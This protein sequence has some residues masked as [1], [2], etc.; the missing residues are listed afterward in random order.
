MKRKALSWLLALCL[1][2]GLLPTAAL[3]AEDDVGDDTPVVSAEPEGDSNSF[4]GIGDDTVEK[5]LAALNPA[6]TLNETADTGTSGGIVWSYEDGVLT[7][8]AAE[9]PESGYD[10]GQMKDYTDQSKKTV[11]IPT[12]WYSVKDEITKVVI[13]NDVTY[14]G[15]WAFSYLINAKEANIPS[16]IKGLGGYLFRGD[17]ELTNV[18]W[19]KNFVAPT[20]TDTDNPVDTYT[21]QY[22]PVSMFDFCYKLGDGIELTDWLPDSF[23]GVCCASLRGTQFTVNFD[24]WENLKYIG[25]YSFSQMPNLN[26]FTMKTDITYGLRNH[27]TTADP[28]NNSNAFNGSGLKSLE[29]PEG[30]TEIFGCMYINCKNLRSISLPSTLK[31]IGQQAFSDCE[32]LDELVINTTS[33]EMGWGV[34]YNCTNLK[35][36]VLK[37]NIT[38]NGTFDSLESVEIYGAVTGSITLSAAKDIVIAGASASMISASKMKTVENLTILGGAELAQYAFLRNTTL[39]NLTFSN[40]LGTNTGLFR[41]SS[42]ETVKY[43]GT[44]T[45]ALAD[46]MFMGCTNLKW[47]D[48]SSA[49]SVTV[50]GG[51]FADDLANNFGG[52]DEDNKGITIPCYINS[53]C[54]IYVSD[55]A[56]AQAVRDSNAGRLPSDKGIVL[57][58]NGGVVNTEAE[59]AGFAAV[60]KDGYTAKWYEYKSN[61]TDYS[62]ETAVTKAQPGK[63]Y[64]V[65]WMPSSYSVAPSLTFDSLTYGSTPVPQTLTVSGVENPSVTSVTGSDSFDATYNGAIVTITPKTGLPVGTYSETIIVTTGDGATHNVDV[66]LTVTKADS[67]VTPGNEDV[68]TGTYG[69]T[70]TLTAK[71]A[72]KSAET[73]A[74]AAIDLYP[75]EDQVAF[76]Y[77]DTKLGTATVSYTENDTGTATLRYDT[78][79]GGIPVG[80]LVS[81]TAAYGGGDNLDKNFTNSI[82]V[83]LSPKALTAPVLTNYTV[84]TTSITVTAPTV[85]TGASKVQYSIDNGKNWQDSNVFSG[86]SSG[87]S[88]SVTAKFVADNT[89]NYADSANSTALSARTNSSGGGGGGTTTYAVAVDSAKNG[90]VSVSPKNASK[91]TAVT[92]TVKPDSGYELDKLTITDKNGEALKLTDK[93]DGKYSFTMPD[94]KVEVKAVFAKKVETSPFGDVSTDAYYYK[95]VQWAQEKGITDGISSNLFGPKQPCTRSQI[96]T[97]LWRAAGSPEPKGT[98]AGMTDVVPGSYYAKAVAWAVENGITTGTAEG[99]FSPDATCTRAQAVTF[100]AR[101]QNAKATGKTAFSDVP[102][103]SYFAD[104]VAW[105]QANGVTTGTSET[106]FSPDNDCTRAQ[107]V[108]FLYRANQG[109]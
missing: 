67:E 74:V 71:V 51:C 10:K 47:V 48:L 13:Q 102:A 12:P 105:A 37:D 19:D 93:G 59:T 8:S 99:T 104:A 32:S 86:L 92:I 75:E 81:V 26:S 17:G 54:V 2:V 11:E 80:Q 20:V 55:D 64:I 44:D 83:Q 97:F 57:I 100:L 33:L 98:A 103:D 15:N 79:K 69:D 29:I 43:T 101:A 23:S 82:K 63:T 1:I 4:Y 42:V 72:K 84:T 49:S 61:L 46:N 38:I 25:A 66:S 76:W 24:A 22:L 30:V 62:K 77:G 7:I 94:G 73:A 27:G 60:N 107:I 88:Y 3:A 85:P 109:T 14:L 21:G 40:S 39:K 78:S 68:V 95:A 89:G 6:E 45:L 58:V 106:T 18:A 41:S 90:S 5:Q 36:L 52:T 35:K 50:G 96:V 28:K 108:T 31:K 9:V 91:G 16:S 70:I 53:N 34:F 65:E 56:V 87:T